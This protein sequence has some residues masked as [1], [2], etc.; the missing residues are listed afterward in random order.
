MSVFEDKVGLD[1]YEY[2]RL[3]DF[4]NDL[5]EEDGS[6]WITVLIWF[7][8]QISECD[9]DPEY[10]SALTFQN[11]FELKSLY[12]PETFEVLTALERVLNSE[13]WGEVEIDAVSTD[14]TR[15]ARKAFR[16]SQAYVPRDWTVNLF[17]WARLIFPKF[18]TPEVKIQAL[19]V[20]V[21]FNHNLYFNLREFIEELYND[22]KW[23]S[24][25]KDPPLNEVRSCLWGDE[26]S[27]VVQI[28]GDDEPNYQ[29]L[30]YDLIHA[31][32]KVSSHANWNVV[33]GVKEIG[34]D[35]EIG[36]GMI[37]RLQDVLIPRRELALVFFK[38]HMRYEKS[39]R[40]T[41]PVFPEFWDYQNDMDAAQETLLEEAQR[42]KEE[43]EFK[44]AEI[45]KKIAQKENPNTIG[46]RSDALRLIQGL[47][48]LNFGQDIL[49]DLVKQRSTSITDIQK[50]LELKG[51]SFDAKTLRKYIKQP[52]TDSE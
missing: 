19:K 2:Y 25:E 28:K 42:E 50:E 33:V 11:P 26:V 16:M 30:R 52:L 20:E 4:I 47:V 7:R 36:N 14:I 35:G 21:N 39:K 31:I 1:P 40:E 22:E 5:A 37:F 13:S 44:K 12:H 3:Q 49:Q 8:S 9:T 29:V 32:S 6:D 34:F 43:Y 46:L 18:W 45:E 24:D 48:V 41:I 17:Y 23:A 38:T 15:P 51:Y 27:C 10:R